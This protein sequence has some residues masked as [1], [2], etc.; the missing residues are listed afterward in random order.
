MSGLGLGSTVGEG[1]GG[2]GAGVGAC[3]GCVGGG[4]AGVPASGGDEKRFD[5]NIPP[6]NPLPAMARVLRRAGAGRLMGDV[7][8]NLGL[9]SN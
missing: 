1:M 3:S 8:T 4:S 7:E 6:M 9:G 2:A 5:M